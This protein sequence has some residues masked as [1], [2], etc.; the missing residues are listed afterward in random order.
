MNL[1]FDIHN[2]IAVKTYLLERNITSEIIDGILIDQ[3]DVNIF[4]MQTTVPMMVKGNV[5]EV[6]ATHYVLE[7]GLADSTIANCNWL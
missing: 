3:R 6:I 2:H 1:T 7:R 4:Q 5:Q